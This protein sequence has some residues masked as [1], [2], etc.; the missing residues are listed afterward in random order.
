MAAPTLRRNFAWSFAGNATYAL[1]QWLIV[2]AIAKLGTPRDV[3]DWTLALAITGPVFVFFQLKLRQFQAT[4][5]RGE[6]R[7]SEYLALRLVGMAS[8]VLV[9]LVV[10]VAGVDRSI[11]IVIAGIAAMKAFD[12]TSDVVYGHHQ[13]HERMHRVGMSLA[14]RGVSG[15]I[16]ATLVLWSTASLE[17]AAFAAAGAYGVWL[18]WDL[19]SIDLPAHEPR[20]PT[21]DLRAVATLAGRVLPLG[22][23]TAIGALQVNIPRYFLEAYVPRAQLGVF[24]SLS[25]VLFTGGVVAGALAT[26]AAPRLARYAAAGEWTAFR[27]QLLQLMGIGATLGVAGILGSLFLGEPV[28]RIVYSA[29]F[30]RHAD[31]LVWL[32][33]T[34]ALTWTYVFLGTALDAMRTYGIQPLIHVVSSLVI[35][36]G[37]ALLVPTHGMRGA[38]WAMLMGHS[39]E[40]IL[41]LTAVT[42]TIRASEAGRT[43]RGAG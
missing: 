22:V 6:H 9:S 25:Y 17:W 43:R 7:W 32:S 34:S 16:A 18:V 40:F 8:A 39:A 23:V 29:E 33:V 37:A 21:R 36:A 27:R 13:Q 15:T 28:L 24:G 38:S 35:T 31:V 2:I 30:A 3:G 1:S 5:I 19:H 10:A 12:V 42:H 41:Y 11:L 14:G 26:A 20:G 4:D